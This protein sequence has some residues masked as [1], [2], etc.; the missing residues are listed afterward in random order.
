MTDLFEILAPI[1]VLAVVGYS[2]VTVIKLLFKPN[3]SQ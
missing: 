3:D 1:V 2:I